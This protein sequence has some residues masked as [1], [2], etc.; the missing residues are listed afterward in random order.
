MIGDDSTDTAIAGYAVDGRMGTESKG[1]HGRA[2]FTA[3]P[4]RRSFNLVSMLD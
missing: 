2:V 4:A 3:L 1:R